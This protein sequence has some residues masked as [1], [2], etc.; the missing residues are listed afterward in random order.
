MR[1]TKGN[2]I[3]PNLTLDYEHSFVRQAVRG[4]YAFDIDASN[5]SPIS[6][7][8]HHMIRQ[9]TGSPFSNLGPKQGPN[10][11]QDVEKE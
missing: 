5:F 9:D 1:Y 3:I 4:S 6:S 2:G 7:P 8:H 11:H 10:K